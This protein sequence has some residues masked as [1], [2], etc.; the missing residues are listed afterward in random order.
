MKNGLPILT[1]FSNLLNK[2]TNQAKIELDVKLIN[3][4]PVVTN[5]D[6]G[7]TKYTITE[8]DVEKSKTHG[9]GL[10]EKDIG[11]VID[12]K[13]HPAIK[14][15]NK[16]SRSF[17]KANNVKTP[18]FEFGNIEDK[19]DLKDRKKI[20]DEAAKELKKMNKTYGF[21]MSNMGT[22]LK[23][24]EERLKEKPLK[25]SDF[26][27]KAI[28]FK[29]MRDSLQDIY[30]SIPLKG[31]RVGP[32]TAA[33]VLD[34]NFFTNVMG[35]PSAEA[36]LGA[37]T[38]FT[39]NKDA[40]RRIGDGI[41]AVTSGT[42]TVDEFIKANGN[43]LTEIAKASVESTPIS[44]DDNIMDDRLKEMDQAMEVPLRAEKY[45]G[46]SVSIDLTMPKFAT[47]GR[48]GFESGTIPGGYTDDAYAYLR[49]IDD[50]IF[51]A[52]KKY[53]AGGGHLK[54]GPY[55]YNA[56]R[57]MFGAFGIGV[58]KAYQRKAEGGIIGD[59]SGPP[60]ERGPNPQGL[61]GLLKRVKNI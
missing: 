23:L 18:I 25:K 41:I 48:I 60:P 34:Y 13:N 42:Q 4:Y 2:K 43:L 27:K 9:Y 37:A 47:G 59:K 26:S 1:R 17:S 55:A 56:K 20:T 22:D 40:A 50:E 54:Y 11:K 53:K 39:K 33:A 12:K 44:K 52:Y 24:I 3:A 57:A 45:G 58:P 61:P 35:V 32:S 46:G 51:N 31:L 14:A 28:V 8:T 6:T 49:E 21:Y 30:N 19:I 16:F 10:T 7:K 5:L 38:W 29:K 15:Y 36:A